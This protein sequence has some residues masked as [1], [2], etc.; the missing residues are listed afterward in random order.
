MPDPLAWID[1]ELMRL[2]A[3]SLQRHLTTHAGKQGPTIEP[4]S[5]LETHRD[6]ET[7][8]KLINFG[9]NDYL[10]LAADPRLA[11]AAKN[12]IDREGW[13]SGASPLITGHSASIAQLETALAKFEATEA[14]LV[15]P[16]GYAANTGAVAALAERGDCIFADQK[17]HASLI[18]GCRLSRADVRIYRHLDMAHLEELLRISNHTGSK[19]TGGASGTRD[20][21]RRLIVTDSL[22][23]MD[24]DIAP[25]DKI[26]TLSEQHSCMLLVDEAHATGVFGEHGRGLCEQFGVEDRVQIRIGTLSKTLGCAGGFVVGSRSLIDWLLN[27]ARSY[28][29]STAGPPAN[30]A[31]ALTALDIVKSEPERRTRLLATAAQLRAALVD[32]GW[33]VGPSERQKVVSQIIPIYIGDANRTMQLSA[34]LREQGLLVPGIRPPSVPQGE[35]LL[36]IS[37]SSGHTPEMIERLIRSLKPLC[38]A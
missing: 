20:Y 30:A 18:D 32:Q 35:S 3:S 37:L 27:R 9:A 17:N 22:F 8:R 23:S 26:A 14:A 4:S 24:G 6:H 28:V 29:F 5:D 12:A 25:L 7:P 11:T 15:F 19:N 13:G 21:R 1:V 10:A 33:N 16:S 38:G 34:Q 36:R 31:A 2:D